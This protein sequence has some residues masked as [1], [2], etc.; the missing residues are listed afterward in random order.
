MI[1]PNLAHIIITLYLFIKKRSYSNNNN[2]NK[3]NIW[4]DHSAK[5][6]TTTTTKGLRFAQICHSSQLNTLA[7]FAAAID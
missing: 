1:I 6:E 2:Q 7:L 3:K 4:N 5:I